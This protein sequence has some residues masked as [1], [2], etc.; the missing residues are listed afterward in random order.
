MPEINPWVHTC[1]K[2]VFVFVSPYLLDKANAFNLS[3]G[4]II[5]GKVQN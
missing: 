3:D 5:I 1:G 2:K 4:V